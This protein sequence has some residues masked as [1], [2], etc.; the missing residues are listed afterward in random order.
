MGIKDSAAVRTSSGNTRSSLNTSA[1]RPSTATTSQTTLRKQKSN[2]TVTSTDNKTVINARPSTQRPGSA[3]KQG[4]DRTST[5]TQTKATLSTQKTATTRATNNA[6]EEKK[7]NTM[8]RSS[9]GIPKPSTTQAKVPTAKASANDRL[10]K[11]TSL[12][13]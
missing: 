11:L 5:L 10:K 8:N 13:D 9:T 3:M 2:M 7:L 4:L 12:A 1:N 6:L